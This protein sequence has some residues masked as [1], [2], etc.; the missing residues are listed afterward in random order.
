MADN[1]LQSREE[2]ASALMSK[3]AIVSKIRISSE[4]DVSQETLLRLHPLLDRA[5][6][7]HKYFIYA[8]RISESCKQSDTNVFDPREV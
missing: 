1:E 6:R 7:L 3:R 8:E 4:I 5:Q 2:I